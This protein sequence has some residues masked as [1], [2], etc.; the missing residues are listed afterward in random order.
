MSLAQ[1]PPDVGPDLPELGPSD[2]SSVWSRFLEVLRQRGIKAPFNRWFVLRVEQF[3]K[4]L[5]NQD[6]GA[7]SQADAAAYLRCVGIREDLKTWQYEQIVDALEIMLADVLRLSWA[8][9]FDWASWRNRAHRREPSHAAVAGK[10]PSQEWAS[11]PFPAPLVCDA[12]ARGR[13]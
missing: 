2:P 12:L 4:A 6:L 5:P 1:E 13:L 9:G 10:P 7:C 3:Q 8:T 11:E